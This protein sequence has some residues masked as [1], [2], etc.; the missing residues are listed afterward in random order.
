MR[1]PLVLD[2]SEEQRK[3]LTR[4]SRS[5]TESVRMVLRAQIVLLRSEGLSKE[6]TAR[7]LGVSEVT[8]QTWTDRFRESGVDGLSDK[9]GRGRKPWID[10]KTRER[11]I[12]EATRPPAGH[13]RHSTRTMAALV[14]VSQHTVRMIWN[15]NDIKPHL[16]RTFKVSKDPEFV[17]KFWDVIGLYLNPPEKAVV[18]CC[19][20]KTQCQALERTQPGLPLGVGHIRTKSHDYIRHGT[21]TLFAALE[22]ATGKVF[23]AHHQTHTHKEWLS[24]LKQIWHIAPKDVSIEIV[25][26]NYA[27][28]KHTDVAEWL[29][30][31]PRIHMH[32]TPTSSSWLN[33]VERFFGEITRDC[34]RDGSF[35]SVAQLEKSISDYI[36]NLNENPKRFVWKADG[37]KI[38]E[39]INRARSAIGMMSLPEAGR[40]DNAEG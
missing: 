32:Y 1:A 4:I 10:E 2:F 9:P 8:V 17:T 16:T 27:T 39:K 7:K 5:R 31:H 13:T 12:T 34:I 33:L 35:T 24:F 40:K 30:K 3:A 36:A 29:K 38:L 11:I 15:R 22:Y 21:T 26:D 25:A 20:E 6:R 18:F 28:H 14:G 23:H 19:D 37:K